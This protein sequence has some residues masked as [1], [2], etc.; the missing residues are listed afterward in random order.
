MTKLGFFDIQKIAI[1]AC[2]VRKKK[3]KKPVIR[4][5]RLNGMLTLIGI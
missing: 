4:S 1:F 2:T 5:N 3:K